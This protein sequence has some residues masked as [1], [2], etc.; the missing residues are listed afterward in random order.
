MPEASRFVIEDLTVRNPD[1]VFVSDLSLSIGCG[2]VLGI[3]GPSGT[4]KSS[5][6]HVLAGLAAPYSGRVLH[7]D[8]P[9][10]PRGGAALGLI[11]QHHHLP[12]MLTAHEAVSLPLQARGVEPLGGRRAQRPH[13]RRPGLGRS[14]PSADLGALRRTAPA[15]GGRQSAG[16]RSRADPR[17]RAHRRSGPGV[18]HSCPRSPPRCRTRRRDRDHRQQ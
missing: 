10:A 6:I 16:R 18:P 17:R 15:R 14:G 7:A 1:T 5:L 12:G 3:T 11:L 13:T 9:V 2:E 8:R 4:G